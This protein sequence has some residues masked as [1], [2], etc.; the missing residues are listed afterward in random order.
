VPRLPS[1]VTAYGHLVRRLTKEDRMRRLSAALVAITAA[2]ALVA[3][4]APAW[5][6]AKPKA[7]TVSKALTVSPAEVRDGQSVKISGGGCQGITVLVFLIDNKEFHRGY[8][9]S[10]NFTYEVKLPRGLV[11]GAHSMGAE[12]RGSK[13]TPAR[14]NVSKKS[15]GWEED[16]KCDVEAWY[17]DSEESEDGEGSYEDNEESEDDESCEDHDKSSK[18]RSR[19]SFNVSPDV[20]TAGDKVWAEGTGCK[21]HSPVTIKLDGRTIKRTYADRHGTFDKGVRLPRHIRKGRHLFSAKCGGRHIGSDGIKVKRTYKQDHDGMHTWG[22]VVQAGKKLK[23]RG[24]DCPDGHP[25]ARM[26]NAPLAL[27]VLSKDK[28]FTAEATIPH[29]T[30]PGRHKFHAGCDAGSFGIT[31]LNVLDPEDNAPAAGQ[32]FGPQPTS[33]LAM[34]AGLFAGL[35]LLVASIVLTTRRRGYRG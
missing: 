17:E 5:P 18:K 4:A 28:G 21:R 14:F 10:G 23:F 15:R 32:A 11:K 35:A 8:T 25:Y 6:K 3:L 7:R 9:K 22:S 13:H 1:P 26:D 27:N 24:D 30:A 2:I 19:A 20:V 33:D 34:W 29:G 12:C 31:Q 16:E